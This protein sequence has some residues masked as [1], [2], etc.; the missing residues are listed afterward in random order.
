MVRHI[1][2]WN[3]KEELTEEEKKYHGQLI[4]SE[5][6]KLKNMI[7]GIISIEVVLKPLNSSDSDLMLDSVFR[8]E[9]ALKAYQ[10]HP[11]HI[12]VGTTIVKPV[13]CNR[14]CLDFEII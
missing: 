10:I 8:D 9:E 5:L 1:V 14:K 13:T 6:E 12:K 11:E 7:D 4:K 3:F 2:A